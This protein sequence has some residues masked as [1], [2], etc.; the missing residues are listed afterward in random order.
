LTLAVGLGF[1]AGAAP[2]SDA[3]SLSAPRLSAGALA[4]QDRQQIS[5]RVWRNDS[6]PS[7]EA[8][9]TVAGLSEDVRLIAVGRQL[10][11]EGLHADGRPL[12]GTRLNGQIRVSGAAAACALCH[13]RS[14]LGA[15]STRIDAPS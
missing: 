13:R 2:E 3:V 5:A 10:Y 4:R 7:Q 1:S 11:L 9:P 6:M 14:G 12:T 8:G 15:C